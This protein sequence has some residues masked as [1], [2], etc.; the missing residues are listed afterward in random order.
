MRLPE[1]SSIGATAS[2]ETARRPLPV[3]VAL[4]LFGVAFWLTAEF[5]ASSQVCVWGDWSYNQTVVPAT[6]T[7]VVALAAGDY[8][9][10][11]LR[12]DGTVIAWGAN[13]CGQK[14][15]PLDATSIVSIAA[16]RAHSLGLR[17]NGTICM[18]GK[19][20]PSNVTNAPAAATNVVALA[21]GSCA[22]HALALRADGTVVDWGDFR[23]GLSNIPPNAVGIVSVAA[24]LDYSLALRSDGR[25]IAWG[26]GVQGE[27]SVP[28]SA[29]NVVA[30]AAGSFA[31]AALRAD[32]TLLVWPA[33][34]PSSYSGF[35]N[36][37][38]VAACPFGSSSGFLGLRRDGTLAQSVSTAPLNAATNVAAIAGGTFN[39]VASAANGPPFFAGVPINRSVIV[40]ATANFRAVAVGAL[41]LSYQWTCNGTNIPGATNC[42]LVLTNV[43]PSLA[44]SQY[45]LNASNPL[46]TATSGAMNLGVVP[47]EVIIQPQMQSVTGGTNVTFTATITGQPATAYQWRFQGANLDGATTNPLVLANVGQSQTGNYSVVCGN[48]YGQATS[49][50]VSLTVIPFTISVQPT[51]QTVPLGANAVFNVVPAGQGP[52]YYQWQRN[53]TNLDGATDNPLVLGNVQFNQQCSYSVLVSNAFGM[54]VSSNAFLTVIPLTIASQ[55]QSQVGFAG[56]GVTFGV[57]PVFQGPFFYQWQFNGTNIA[58]ATESLLVLTNL[59]FSQAGTYSVLVSNQWSAV[60]SASA[61][62]DV[63]QVAVWGPD[64]S[65]ET[66]I[67]DDLTNAVGI[68]GGC[69]FSVAVRS[70]GRISVWGQAWNDYGVGITNV[71]LDLTN[72]VAVA[73]GCPHALALR[74]DGTV[75]VWGNYE[76]SSTNYPAVVPAGLTDIV[77]VAAGWDSAFA[78][79]ADGT[80]TAWGSDTAAARVPPGLTNVVQVAGGAAYAM[81]L[82]SDGTIAIWG[83]QPGTGDTTLPP[84]LSNVIAIAAG[85]YHGLALQADGKVVAWGNNTNGQ[86]NIPPHWTNIVALAAGW[87][88]SMALRNDGAVLVCGN[89]VTNL[90][91]NLSSAAVIACGAQHAMALPGHPTLSAL[92]VRPILNSAGFSLSLPAENGKVYRL[93]YTSSLSEPNWTPLPLVAGRAGNISL[94]DPHATNNSQRFYRVRRW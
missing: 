1:A 10:M 6:A 56:L 18:W 76:S 85:V 24:G 36:L 39:G 51:N 42:I 11:A 93:E 43:Q 73:A 35:T 63:N 66:S 86:T 21:P 64:N 72:A 89:T 54:A 31:S 55:P 16:G 65:G 29:T 4:F 82:R 60:K 44:G 70:D 45:S 83:G 41:P 49:A 13:Y 47:M 61:V 7:N 22:Q 90:P 88:W 75:S 27:T 62:L 71:P 46:G 59:Q 23:Y 9:C 2:P 40:G 94:T 17:S 26:N 78:L 38:D 79:K 32:G 25:V 87:D 28:A 77:A 57:T 80:V 74:N 15:V 20:L 33:P 19:I 37:I 48:S 69:G 30:I 5:Q 50:D 68:A 92:G 53:G 81:A 14:N 91:S 34:A 12:R 58:D 84:Y 8:H 52:F 3:H 67:P